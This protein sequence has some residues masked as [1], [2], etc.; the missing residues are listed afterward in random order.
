MTQHASDGAA[1]M[2]DGDG[3]GDRA[4]LGAVGVVAGSRSI[5]LGLLLAAVAFFFVDDP[6]RAAS[7]KSRIS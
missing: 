7:N 5:V 6:A 2:V 3:G 4:Q 1:P